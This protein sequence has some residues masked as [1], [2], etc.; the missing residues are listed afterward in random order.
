[1]FFSNSPLSSRGKLKQLLWFTSFEWLV[2]K[3]YGLFYF[4]YLS[5]DLYT[6]T[7]IKSDLAFGD[8]ILSKDD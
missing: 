1:M 7:M 5:A 4:F 8:I 6:L 3:K 2:H